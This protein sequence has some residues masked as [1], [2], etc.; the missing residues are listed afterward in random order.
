MGLGQCHADAMTRGPGGQ[1]KSGNGF[2]GQ[3]ERN[4]RRP[5]IISGT[6]TVMMF[7]SVSLSIPRYPWIN[8]LRVAMICR[9]GMW[10][11]E[12]LTG[13]GTLPAA[14][15]RPPNTLPTRGARTAL[16][17]RGSASPQAISY[18]GDAGCQL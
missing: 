12:A 8:R 1:P 3:D 10:E 6:S 4:I 9:H 2:A 18:W 14:C 11:F 16:T 17:A 7:Q 15:K 5:S 13:S